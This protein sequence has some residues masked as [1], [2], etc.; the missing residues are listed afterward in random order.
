MAVIRAR[1][2]DGVFNDFTLNFHY[3]LT[4][5]GEVN[6]KAAMVDILGNLLGLTTN[7]GNFLTPEI[8]Y[9]K[10]TALC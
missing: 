10:N 5:V 6:S 4:S 3:E 1:G 8:R 7:Y 2:L 9:N